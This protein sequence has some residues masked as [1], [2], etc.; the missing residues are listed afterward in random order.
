MIA[1]SRSFTLL[2]PQSSKMKLKVLLIPVIVILNLAAV[3]SKSGNSVIACSDQFWLKL[4]SWHVAAS[5]SLCFC[6][7]ILPICVDGAEPIVHSGECCPR[8][9][10]P[11]EP[12][13]LDCRLVLCPAPDCL[14]PLPPKPGQCCPTC[15]SMYIMIVCSHFRHVPCKEFWCFVAYNYVTIICNGYSKKKKSVMSTTV[16][17]L[18]T[19][20]QKKRLQP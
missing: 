8:C 2:S 4:P 16:F 7:A 20:E 3:H 13:T 10:A 5:A 9:P 17:D 1:I 19:S 6:P 14:R 12:P 15:P 11:T 18:A